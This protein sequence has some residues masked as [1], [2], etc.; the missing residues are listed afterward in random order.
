MDEYALKRQRNNAAVSRTRQKKR[1]EQ[2]HTS[3]RVKELREENAQ[4][5]RWEE[6]G[7]EGERLAEKTRK[8]ELKYPKEPQS[9]DMP[10]S[11]KT[12]SSVNENRFYRQGIKK[13]T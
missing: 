6:G 2:A 11:S 5:E 10:R 13:F 3:Q 7:D 4:L 12:T 1:M 8:M 9:V